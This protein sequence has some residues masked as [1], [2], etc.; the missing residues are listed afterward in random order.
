[1][2]GHYSCHWFGPEIA[3][4]G[5]YYAICCTPCFVC[6]YDWMYRSLFLA[7]VSSMGVTTHQVVYLFLSKNSILLLIIVELLVM[8]L[9]EW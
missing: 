2:T 7:L 9:F 6:L 5:C 1:M 8:D 3:Q 4:M